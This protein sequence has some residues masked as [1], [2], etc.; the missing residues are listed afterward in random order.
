MA[1]NSA[2]GSG[3]GANKLAGKS[4]KVIGGS[5]HT[6]TSG[7]TGDSLHIFNSLS[8]TDQA[9]LARVGQ[10]AYVEAVNVGG[11]TYIQAVDNSQAVGIV[12]SSK[13]GAI[14]S[15]IHNG[16]FDLSVHLPNGT[17]L[18]LE[19][20][21]PLLTAIETKSYF[22]GLINGWIPGQST[23]KDAFNAAVAKAANHSGDGSAVRLVTPDDQSVGSGYLALSGNSSVNETV[24][25]NMYGVKSGHAVQISDFDSSVIAGPGA[26]NVAGSVGAFV[27][28]DAADQK[29][30]GG[31]GNDTL[32][33]GSGND[34]LTGGSGADIFGVGFTGNTMIT[35]FNSAAGDKLSFNSSMTL[36]SLLRAE[37]SVVHVGAFAITDIA[38][39]G[40]NIYLVGV[41]PSQLTLDMLLFNS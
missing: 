14:D 12:I 18:K 39:D 4:P 32:F 35:D 7:L 22:N 21:E 24:V 17:S 23:Y 8:T 19:G 33:G 40:N 26:V 6:G 10:S 29:I 31:S 11:G 41:D 38:L 2:V 3:T 16:N 30:T 36:Q 25:I 1:S 37:V 9:S 15:H 5:S 27:I 20:P 28:G 13:T 34:I